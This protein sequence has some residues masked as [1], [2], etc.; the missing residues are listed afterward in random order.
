MASQVLGYPRKT[1]SE[2]A[3][4]IRAVKGMRGEPDGFVGTGDDGFAV[5]TQLGS[6]TPS[7]SNFLRGDGTW[8]TSTVGSVVSD[9]VK[10]TVDATTTSASLADVTALTFA[11]TSG[12]YYH[13]RYVLV[14][15]TSLSTCGPVLA[16]VHPGATVF[17]AIVTNP[18]GEG[19]SLNTSGTSVTVADLPAASTSYAISIE[20]VILP[21]S[22]GDLKV[23]FAAEV[24]TNTITIKQGSSGL[25]T[26]IP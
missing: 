7:S 4:T 3:R 26:E 5:E 9:G 1:L 13:F 12:T 24:A 8:A 25:L 20:G 2:Q 21:N 17:G 16:M 18:V 11:V 10:V 22:T 23:Q 6:G 14:V 15:Q 19:G